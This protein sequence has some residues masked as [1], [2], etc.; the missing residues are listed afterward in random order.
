MAGQ[1]V[2]LTTRII[3]RATCPDGKAQHDLWDA[4]QP[5]LVL[6]VYPTGRKVFLAFYRVGTG[7]KAEQRW[8]R[9]GRADK[10]ALRDARQA[11]REIMGAVA[12]G[13]DPVGD[14]KAEQKRS[15]QRLGAALDGYE[16]DLEHRRVVKRRDVLSL[17]RREL[18]APIGNVEL[19]TLDRATLAKRI[20]EVK[21][22][23]RPGAARELKVRA[24]VFLGWATDEG[25]INANPLAGWRLKRATRA[26]RIERPG[27]A[28]ADW[29]LPIFWNAA[30]GADWPFNPYLKILLLLGQR[31]TETAM[32]RWRDLDLAE[33][34][35]IVPPAITKSGRPHKIP[36]PRQAVE[37]LK[38]LPRLAGTDLVFPGRRNRPMS[39]WSKH[40]PPVYKATAAAGMA[41]WAP[42]D[43]RRT[44]RSGLSALGVERVT[45]ELL[46]DHAVSDELSK[47]YDRHEY[48]PQRVE[49]SSRW[50]THVLGLVEGGG[51]A[52][53][54]MRARAG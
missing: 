42:H 45:A 47:I 44:M 46:L 13:G 29:E 8:P 26:E 43:L 30:S 7:R 51:G 14:R 19:E 48:W 39:G 41:A 9:I 6:R 53:V 49:A 52:V 18:L 25:L 12:K 1:R 17:L 3:E 34:V 32:M 23:G 50:A 2:K 22:S 40:L 33:G 28:L 4:D 5:G 36:I 35:W 31:R 20:T 11:A 27:R 21:R 54:P 37:I 10:I 38:G 15:R 24:N 16:A